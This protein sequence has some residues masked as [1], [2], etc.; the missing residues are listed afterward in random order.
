MAVLV[1][2]RSEMGGLFLTARHVSYGVARSFQFQSR[3]AQGIIIASA[4]FFGAYHWNISAWTR[5]ILA[6]CYSVVGVPSS[7][8]A[9]R[10]PKPQLPGE[11]DD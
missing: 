3:P 2:G 7:V 9:A 10:G 1:E 6:S 4:S 5:G 11:K 8:V